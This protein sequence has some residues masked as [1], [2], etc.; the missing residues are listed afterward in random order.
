MT[1]EVAEFKLSKIS[2][3]LEVVFESLLACALLL[4]ATYVIGDVRGFTL[5]L[6]MFAIYGGGVIFL[7]RVLLRLRYQYILDI[8]YVV[9]R[10]GISVEEDQTQKT[11]KWNEFTK[12]EYLP[13][14]TVYR[15]WV[16]GQTR[17]VVLIAIGGFPGGKMDR[18]NKIAGDLI[19]QGLGNRLKKRWLPW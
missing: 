6:G 18:R 8:R 19:R 10:D 9:G 1:S 15:L 17:P 16:A 4:L 14:V 5:W 2:S 3:Y 11:F 13:I 12:A 7:S